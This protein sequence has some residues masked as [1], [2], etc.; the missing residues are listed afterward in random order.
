MRTEQREIK[1]QTVEWKTVYISNDNKEFNTEEDCKKWEQSVEALLFSK[2]KEF[3]I[4]SK[5]DTIFDEGDENQYDTLVPTKQ[6]HLDAINQLYFMFG[7]RSSDGKPKKPEVTEEDLNTPILFGY[8]FYCNAVDWVWF[9]KVST[10]VSSITRGT[11]TLQP[12]NSTPN[13]SVLHGSEAS[14]VLQSTDEV[15]LPEGVAN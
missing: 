1:K 2:L 14:R 9:H 10:I 4:A 11:Y 8:R 6:E 13:S 5:V 3:T 15:G 12:A 7:G